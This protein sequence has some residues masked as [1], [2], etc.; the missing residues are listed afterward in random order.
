MEDFKELR[1]LTVFDVVRMA[2]ERGFIVGE[3]VMDSQRLIKFCNVLGFDVEDI[4][5]FLFL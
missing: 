1:K 2:R 5:R 3:V 4:K